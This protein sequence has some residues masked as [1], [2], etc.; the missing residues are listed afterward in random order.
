MDEKMIEAVAR[1]LAGEE[2][3]AKDFTETLSGDDPADMQGYWRDK[4]KAA[5]EAMEPFIEE[6]DDR[7]IDIWEAGSR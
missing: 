7:I 4:A 3:T 2:W 5:I 6:R 1:A